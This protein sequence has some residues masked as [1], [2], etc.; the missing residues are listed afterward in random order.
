[1]D[2]SGYLNAHLT[3]FQFKNLNEINNKKVIIN[4]GNDNQDFITELYQ[5][6]KPYSIY[7]GSHGDIGAKFAD[8]VLPVSAWTETNGHYSNIEG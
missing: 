3:N 8:L 4:L 2:Y 6:Q 1:M 7:I 5:K